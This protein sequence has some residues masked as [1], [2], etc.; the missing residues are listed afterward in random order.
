MK[1]LCKDV[2]NDETLS[3][4]VDKS[5]T[6]NLNFTEADFSSEES[7]FDRTVKSNSEQICILSP[8]SVR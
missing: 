1:P 5:K 4:T 3:A 6:D 8:C 2:K 7:N